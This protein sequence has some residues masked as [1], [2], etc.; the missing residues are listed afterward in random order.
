MAELIHRDFR[1]AGQEIGRVFTVGQEAEFVF[2]RGTCHFSRS[3]VEIYGTTQSRVVDDAGEKWF[4]FGFQIDCTLSGNASAGWTDAGNYF[5]LEP[6]W[7]PD[8]VN[9]SMGKFISRPTVDRGDGTWEYWGRALNPQDSAV[10]TGSLFFANTMGDDRVNGF[11][12]CI[13]A[14]VTLALPNFPYNLAVAGT[15]AQLQTD[16]RAAGYA[17]TLVTGT[18]A[19]N[20]TVLIPSVNYTS[21]AAASWLGFPGFLV[22]NVFGELVN[23]INTIHPVG[24]FVDAS[25]TPIFRAAFARL[26]ISAGPRYD[27]YA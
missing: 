16:L 3:P 24:V 5:R 12:S 8:L 22:K 10:K 27:P 23:L 15:A 17:G 7:S 2:G 18:T 21:Y 9:W 25:G 19:L 26:K 20:W 6:Q 4:E 1:T 13:I 14:G 11:T